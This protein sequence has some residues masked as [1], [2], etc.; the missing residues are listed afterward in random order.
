MIQSF[1]RDSLRKHHKPFGEEKN[2]KQYKQ[3]RIYKLNISKARYL[4][5]KEFD[6]ENKLS[7]ICMKCVEWQYTRLIDRYG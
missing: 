3:K 6:D 5:L 4:T 7:C 1:Q 2:D